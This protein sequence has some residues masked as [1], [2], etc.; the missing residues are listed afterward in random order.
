MI[1]NPAVGRN[2]DF[3]SD[4]IKNSYVAYIS[5]I[6]RYPGWQFSQILISNHFPAIPFIHDSHKVLK[7]GKKWGISIFAVFRRHRPQTQ[8]CPDCNG[9]SLNIRKYI[10]FVLVNLFFPNCVTLKKEKIFSIDL[11]RIP[12]ANFYRPISKRSSRNTEKEGTQQ[13]A[14]TF[15][16]VVLWRHPN[17]IIY[18][19]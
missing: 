17:I 3:S 10:S 12:S 11:I 9:Y 5:E 15:S 16:D 1:E 6:W 18:L 4:S 7:E 14:P 19:I 8:V 2:R 13:H